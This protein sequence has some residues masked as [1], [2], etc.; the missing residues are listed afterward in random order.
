[1]QMQYPDNTKMEY[2]HDSR[3]VMTLDAGGTSF[4]FSAIRGNREVTQTVVMP[5]ET[6][7]LELCL[8]EI[9]EGFMRVEALCPARAVAV[10]FAFPGPAIT[11]W[12]HR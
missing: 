11:R 10:S 5:A 12:H 6:M 1:M 9:T 4:R 3:V 7:D 8:R 2:N